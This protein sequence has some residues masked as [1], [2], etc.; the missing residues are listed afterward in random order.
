MRPGVLIGYSACQITREAFDLAGCDAWTC[1]LLPAR[2]A[3]QKHLQIDIWKALKSR[4]WDAAIL[5]PMCTY[6]TLS[7]A[8]AYGD[9]PYH[10]KVKPETLTGSA[11]RAA[12][13]EALRNFDALLALPF[14]VGVEN[15]A[16][17]FV[18]R[19]IRAPSQMVQPYQYGDDA[20]KSTGLWLEGLPLLTPTQFIAPRLVCSRGHIFKFGQ[21]QCPLCGSTKYLP[22]WANQTDTGQNR[23][24]P[25][26]DRWLQRAQTYP[27]IAAAMGA[28][29]GRY[30]VEAH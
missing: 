7:A 30:L 25:S 17:S 8:W 20:S 24:T 15:P 12:R 6:L 29:W 28:Q 26:D 9:G 1:D 21:T 11:R 5:H 19:A 18:N 16:P 27:G 4:L 23:L 13:D 14:P 3:S 22:R 2:G 10:Q